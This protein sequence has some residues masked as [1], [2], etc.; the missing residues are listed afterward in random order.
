MLIGAVVAAGAAFCVGRTVAT[1]QRTRAVGGQPAWLAQASPEAVQAEER[2]EQLARQQMDVLHA[3]RAV[4]AS[5]L[6]DTQFTGEQILDQVEK[7]MQT[8]A[9]LAKSVGVHLAN[10]QGILPPLQGQRLMSSCANSLQGSLQ[11]RYRWRGGAQDQGERFMGGR[12]GRGGWGAGHGRQY[13]GGRSDSTSGLARR[14]QLTQEQNTWIQQQDPNF[15]EQCALL[16]EKLYEAHASLVASIESAQ[17][18]EQELATKVDDL[19]AAHE[20]LETRV[21][22]H[23]V[24]LRPQLSQEQRNLLSDLCGAR[25][26]EN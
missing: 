15:A 12:R 3:E 14:L 17:A 21:A 7:V 13:R 24:L 19:I 22:Q 10:L 8:H 9:A 26:A 6:S 11:R 1:T 5:M 18:T 2:F 20:A 4:L 16:N 25:Y 23:I